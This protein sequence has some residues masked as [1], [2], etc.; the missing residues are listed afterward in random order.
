MICLA[1][2]HK[3]GKWGFGDR[4]SHFRGCPMVSPPKSI[5]VRSGR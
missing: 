4:R 3:I 1:C 5:E 2:G